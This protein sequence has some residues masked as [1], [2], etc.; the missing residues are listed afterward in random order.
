M[1]VYIYNN[2]PKYFFGPMPPSVLLDFV[3]LPAGH[4]RS[5]T[6]AHEALLRCPDI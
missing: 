4:G 5:V 6:D 3:V 1:L 2:G